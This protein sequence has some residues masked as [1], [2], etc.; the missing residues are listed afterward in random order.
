MKALGMI[1]VY[2]YLAAVE[3]LDSALKAANVSLVDVVK[4]KGGLV[5]VLVEG[6]VGAVK[7]AMD[8]SAAAAERVGRIMSVHVIPRP[9][10]DVG[11][12]LTKDKEH[13]PM[14]HTN[15]ELLTRPGQSPEEQNQ[16]EQNQEEQNQEDKNQEE[17]VKEGPEISEFTREQLEQ[18]TVAELRKLARD[19]GITNMTRQEIRF[20]KKQ[21]LIHAILNDS[22]QEK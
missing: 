9:A 11:R 7:A 3:A 4:V 13:P 22:R 10:E 19:I 2:G 16:E 14:T 18:M 1:E 12:M 17:Q 8:A 6:E 20:A 5:T 21:E 15:E